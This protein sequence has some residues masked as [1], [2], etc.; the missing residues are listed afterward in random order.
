MKVV[1]VEKIQAMKAEMEKEYSQIQQSISDLQQRAFA[2]QAAFKAIE[3]LEKQA[4]IVEG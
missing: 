4:E 2:T 3:S 1:S